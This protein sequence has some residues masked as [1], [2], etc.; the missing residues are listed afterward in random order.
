MAISVKIGMY[1]YALTFIPLALVE[2]CYFRSHSLGGVLNVK[3][4]IS[5]VLTSLL[6]F[7]RAWI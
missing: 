3:H 5:C 2:R 1:R 6:F 4:G 7:R